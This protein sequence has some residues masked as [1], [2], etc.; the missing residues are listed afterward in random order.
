M[1]EILKVYTDGGSRGN[2]G[3]AGIGVYIENEKG[4]TVFEAKQFLGLKTNN[5]AE[6]LA[7]IRAV[8]F[9][10]N[11]CSDAIEV[12]REIIIEFYSDSKLVVEQ[13]NK[14]W[15]IKEPRLQELS[16]EAWLILAS[17]P[18]SYRI[19]HILRAGNK[20]ADLLANLAMDAAN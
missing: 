3:K 9:L 16:K 1:R 19:Q 6:Y 12:G 14:N 4:E 2:P 15:K 17:L 18:Y 11:Y 5:E 20:R 8:K 10:Q 13:L 7:F